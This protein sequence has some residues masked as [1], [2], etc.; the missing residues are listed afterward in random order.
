MR[1]HEIRSHKSLRES[2]TS[3]FYRKLLEFLWETVANCGFFIESRGILHG[4]LWGFIGHKCG[5]CRPG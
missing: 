1:F 3:H 5:I 2:Q 4:I